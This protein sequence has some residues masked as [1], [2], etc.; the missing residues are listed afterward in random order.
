MMR[1]FVAAIIVVAVVVGVLALSLDPDKLVKLIIFR[2][3]FDV[4]MPILGFGALIKYLCSGC[5]KCSDCHGG[6]YRK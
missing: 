1:I 4:T 3:F 5:S 2:N 6:G